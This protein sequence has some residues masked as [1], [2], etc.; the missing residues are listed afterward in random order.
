[1]L[2]RVVCNDKGYILGFT[3]VLVLLLTMAVGTTSTLL[4]LTNKSQKHV[5]QDNQAF[6]MAQSGL[7]MAEH[8]LLNLGQQPDEDYQYP[9]DLPWLESQEEYFQ[10]GNA[11]KV[12][13]KWEDSETLIVTSKGLSKDQERV[14]EMKVIISNSSIFPATGIV[15]TKPGQPNYDPTYRWQH[16]AF[17]PPS[18]VTS[19]GLLNQG[20]SLY[21]NHKY[22]GIELGNREVLTINGPADLFVDGNIEMK[23]GSKIVFQGTG[24]VRIFLTGNINCK[25]G[26]ILDL[27]IP[28]ELY[29]QGG[30]PQNLVFYNSFHGS[31]VSA[32]Y[33]LIMA[34]TE[35]YNDGD[36]QP[37]E[38]S[39]NN[40]TINMKNKSYCAMGVFAPNSHVTFN[41]SPNHGER[42]FGSVVARMVTAGGHD[43][44]DYVEYDGSL[45][46][47]GYSNEYAEVLADSWREVE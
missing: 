42:I 5:E 30:S 28:L 37:F 29:L 25:N 24:K 40:I 36:P 18:D 3:I 6:Y 41:G 39:F 34:T 16:L 38:P 46:N 1:M 4:V 32:Q 31:A 17:E 26:S 44:T 13:T 45:G 22:T 7:K 8:K 14:L 23:N 9:D 2:K 10:E 21:G 35:G 11:F 12:W 15:E 33:F 19:E 43:A 27:N 20:E 47:I